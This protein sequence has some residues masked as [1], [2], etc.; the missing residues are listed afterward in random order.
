MKEER[1]FVG[2][3][4]KCTNYTNIKKVIN[5]RVELE[6]VLRESELIKENTVLMKT[7]N[8]L[9][10]EIDG[11]NICEMALLYNASVG[12]KLLKTKPTFQN[13]LYVDE[14]SLK[15]YDEYY[16]FNKKQ[17]CK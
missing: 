2:N 16:G 3:V 7:K 4:M 15:A 5:N 14:G 11:L 13:E 12:K 10:S 9:Y 6:Y 1:I 8:G 17:K